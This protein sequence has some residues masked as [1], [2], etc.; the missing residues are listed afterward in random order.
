MVR[1]FRV[2]RS[3]VKFV[4]RPRCFK[5]QDHHALLGDYFNK[6]PSGRETTRGRVT[7]QLRTIARVR[8]CMEKDS[9]GQGLG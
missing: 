4:H 2:T 9:F 5:A 8:N 7:D 6:K 1:L 3:G